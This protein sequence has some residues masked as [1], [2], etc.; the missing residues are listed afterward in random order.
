MRDYL[1]FW[2]DDLGNG[3][4]DNCN[5][6]GYGTRH[7]GSSGRRDGRSPMEQNPTRVNA[8]VG[9]GAQGEAPDKLL[10]HGMEAQG[11][12]NLWQGGERRVKSK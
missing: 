9:Y 7:Y 11:G 4:C 2:A 8:I 12:I 1:E 5:T 3:D 10:L 6:L